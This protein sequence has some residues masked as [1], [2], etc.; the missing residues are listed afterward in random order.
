MIYIKRLNF[1]FIR[2]PKNAS[3]T[4]MHYLYQNAC[5]QKKDI[6]THGFTEYPER[7]SFIN[8]P[9]LEHSHIDAQFAIDKLNIPLDSKFV[10]VIRNPLEKQLSLYM[11]RILNNIYG[12]KPSPEHFRSMLDNGELKD[13][14]PWQIQHQHTFLKYNENNIGT[15]WLYDNI[16]DHLFEFM[17]EYDITERIPLQKLNASPGIKKNLIDIFYDSDTK[18]QAMKAFKK[19]IELYEK[20]KERWKL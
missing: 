11:F 16:D 1:C 12:V 18:A 2:V 10:G 3:S 20:A 15:W 4:I 5:D 6:I 9:R 8:C 17:K 13:T 7:I 14:R 19:D